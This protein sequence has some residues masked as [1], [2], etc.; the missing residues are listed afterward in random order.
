MNMSLPIDWWLLPA[1]VTVAGIAWAIPM[2]E[3]EQQ[4]G[5]MFS[6]MAYAFGAAVRLLLACIAALAAW[7]IWSIFA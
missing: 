6:G 7:L 2:R 4:D 1:A 5:T 3:D